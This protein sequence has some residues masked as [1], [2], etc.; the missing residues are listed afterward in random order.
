MLH[1]L[2]LLKPGQRIN[3]FVILR[4][5]ATSGASALYLARPADAGR[6][7]ERATGLLGRLRPRYRLAALKLA[8]ADFQANLHDEHDYLSRVEL[9]HPHLVALYSQR[10]RPGEPGPRDLGLA[11]LP[12]GKAGDRCSVP[13]LALA[14]EPGPTLARVLRQRRGR[15]LDPTL[16]AHIAHQTAQALHHLHTHGIIHHD[17]KP[18]N[19]MLRPT[20]GIADVALIDLGAAESLR[21]PR[22]R[23]IYG[24]RRYLPPERLSGG[25]LETLTLHIDIYGLGR[26]LQEMLLSAPED[27]DNIAPGEAGAARASHAHISAELAQLARDATAQSL[28]ERR[29]RVPSMRTFIERLEAT[30]EF[31]RTPTP[32]HLSRRW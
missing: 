10:R 29:R 4:P 32:P 16:A 1:N 3:E 18:G 2:P 19:I 26:A 23:S 14:F 21:A 13:Y 17:V 30:P 24:T 15:P 7:R 31:R 27:E 28:E 11:R 8:R 5:I 25:G 9:R 12:G 6:L 22:Q 20:R